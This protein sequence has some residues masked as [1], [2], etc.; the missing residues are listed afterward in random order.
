MTYTEANRVAS[1]LK[2]HGMNINAIR[3]YHAHDPAS[4]AVE[5]TDPRT[6]TPVTVHDAREWSDLAAAAPTPAA[7]RPPVY[8]ETMEPH[9][10]RMTAAQWAHVKAQGGDY[11]NGLRAIVQRDMKGGR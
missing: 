9:T 5:A 11:S 3:R 10:I 2:R 7:G 6:D 1:A 8:G 4:W